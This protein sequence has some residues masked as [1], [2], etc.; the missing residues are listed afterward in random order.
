MMVGVAIGVVGV[1]MGELTVLR[2]SGGFNMD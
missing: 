1:A 2:G